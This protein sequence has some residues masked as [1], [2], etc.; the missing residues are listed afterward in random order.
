MFIFNPERLIVKSVQSQYL[1]RKCPFETRWKST[2]TV[3][4]AI[5][6]HLYFYQCTLFYRYIYK[7]ANCSNNQAPGHQSWPIPPDLD[8]QSNAQKDHTMGM[9]SPTFKKHRKTSHSTF[10]THGHIQHHHQPHSRLPLNCCRLHC[11]SLAL[12]ITKNTWNL[13]TYCQQ[14]HLQQSLT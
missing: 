6:R 3:D 2:L 7:M 11:L 8:I 12:T 4:W 9:T 1:P 13:N 10:P 5:P 14:C